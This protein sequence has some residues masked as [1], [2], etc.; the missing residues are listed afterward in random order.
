MKKLG[1]ESN[2]NV[3]FIFFCNKSKKNFNICFLFSKTYANFAPFKLVTYIK[4]K[5]NIHNVI[6]PLYDDENLK[7]VN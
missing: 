7:A 5:S 2:F 1:L 6:L 4:I 3:N